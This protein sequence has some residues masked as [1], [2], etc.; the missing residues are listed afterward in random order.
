MNTD[1]FTA[2]LNRARAQEAADL[3][4]A[5]NGNIPKTVD[6]REMIAQSLRANW[7]RALVAS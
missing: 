1:T 4:R 2:A 6:P 7:Q 3:A 5:I